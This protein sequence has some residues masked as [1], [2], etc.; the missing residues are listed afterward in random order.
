[1]EKSKLLTEINNIG[2]A[3][4]NKND[5]KKLKDPIFLEQIHSFEVVRVTRPNAV[6]K[7]ADAMVT[8]VPGLKLTLK[9]ADCAPVLLADKKRG[10]VA[11]AHAGWKGS[12]SGILET[13]L[14][15]MVRLGA[16]P[17]NI[18]AAIG[19]CIHVNS[20][21]VEEEMKQLFTE[22]VQEFFVKRRGTEHFDL[23]GY[24]AYRLYR[25]GLK[26]VDIID[27]NT[28]TD[29]RYNSYRRDPSNPARQFSSIW[30]EE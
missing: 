22:N 17:D 10:V 21:P 24:V 13:T 26:E 9:T 29:K 2:H 19:P 6:L 15:E 20:Y 5:S 7:P 1:M 28:Y 25:A 3:F 16:W 18:V 8:C 4:Y 23:P 14:L 11:A 12:F 27:V 30:V